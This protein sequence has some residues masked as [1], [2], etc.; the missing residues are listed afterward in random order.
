MHLPLLLVLPLLPAPPPPTPTPPTPTHPPTH[1]LKRPASRIS[2]VPG[3][4]LARSLVGRRITLRARGTGASS[5]HKEVKQREGC[6]SGVEGSGVEGQRREGRRTIRC[7]ATV[8][9]ARRPG[10][11]RSGRTS[12]LA[13]L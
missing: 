6:I 12:T 10:R 1:T 4:M 8:G 5:A 9:A 3:V 2:T 11:C 7:Q 13:A